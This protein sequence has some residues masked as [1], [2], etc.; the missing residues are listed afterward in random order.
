MIRPFVLEPIM[1]GRT[2]PVAN[3]TFLVTLFPEM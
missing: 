3:D 2:A 1:F